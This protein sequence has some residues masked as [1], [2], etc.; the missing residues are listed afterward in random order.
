MKQSDVAFSHSLQATSDKEN[1][2][3]VF[4]KSP[5]IYSMFEV[6]MNE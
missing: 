2:K 3:E 1:K 4:L 6:V 5:E